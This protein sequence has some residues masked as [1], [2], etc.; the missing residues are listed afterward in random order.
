MSS[1]RLARAARIH[2]RDKVAV[3]EVVLPPIGDDELLLRVVSSSMCLSTYKAMSLGSEHKRVPDT[4]SSDPVIT[5]HEFAGVLEEVGDELAQPVER[6]SERRRPDDGRRECEL[7]PL[8]FG[9]VHLHRRL[10]RAAARTDCHERE[11]HG[12]HP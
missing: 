6:G 3:G 1:E 4:I 11:E 8:H 2:G 9:V 7:H 10:L 5:G 12:G